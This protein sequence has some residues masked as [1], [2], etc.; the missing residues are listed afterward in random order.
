MIGAYKNGNYMVQIFEN[1]TK[2]RICKEDKFEPAFP[3]SIDLKITNQC[4]MNCAY[5]HEGS[6]EDG[7]HGNIDAKFIDSLHPYTE[8]AIGGGNPLAHPGLRDL[9]QRLKENRIIANMT[10]HQRHYLEQFDKIK[11]LY[12][13]K[14]IYGI[15]V[16]INSVGYE[17]LIPALKA[18]PTVVCHVIAGVIDDKILDTLANNGLN[19]LILGYKDLRR[20]HRFKSDLIIQ[21]I[22]WLAENIELYKNKFPYIAFDNLAIEQLRMKNKVDKDLL[23]ELYMG[24]DGQF[25]MFIDLVEEQ[26][27]SSS[28]SLS[29]YEIDNKIEDMFKRV[30]YDRDFSKHYNF[31]AGM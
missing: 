24:D 11:Q 8:V 5:C 25:T 31:E 27:A 9:L 14:L 30:Q 1:G 22:D 29:R 3:E 7:K 6:T 4:N 23:D 18:I 19:L 15:G 20:G 28:T 2:M 21:G 16:S 13:E 26:F 12:E 17:G 10:V